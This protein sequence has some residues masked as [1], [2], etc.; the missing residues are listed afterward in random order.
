MPIH[1]F[2]FKIRIKYLKMYWFVKCSYPCRCRSERV[3]LVWKADSF[4]L[5]PGKQ[6]P[7][8]DSYCP[9]RETWPWELGSGDLHLHQQSLPGSCDQSAL[10]WSPEQPRLHDACR[11]PSKR[12]RQQNCWQR[13]CTSTQP[14]VQAG[15]G[16]GV[17]FSSGVR[18][19]R[20]FCCGCGHGPQWPAM[21]HY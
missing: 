6:W 8:S 11:A 20:G 3:M 14:S 15:S 10:P 4:C 1:S 17:S 9:G 12:W 7:E 19:E 5:E 2:I 21:I 13:Q 16:E 18:Q